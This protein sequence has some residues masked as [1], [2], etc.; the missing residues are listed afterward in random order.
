MIPTMTLNRFVQQKEKAHPG[1]TG[2]LSELLSSI[3]LGIKLISNLVQT[4]AF[5]GLHGYTG[6]VNV[7]GEHT[8]KL[9]EQSNEVLTEILGSLGH[10]GLL[11]SEET[12]NVIPTSAK[13]DQSKYVVA[14]D[15]LDG[16]SNLGVNV[17]VGT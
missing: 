5:K 1:A 15:P 11:V 7:Q 3:A 2:E 9:D 16:S 12:D 8:Q 14:F 4:A 13:K 17:S 10:F 6:S